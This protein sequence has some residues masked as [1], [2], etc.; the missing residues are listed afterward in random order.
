LSEFAYVASHDLK[1]PLSVVSNFAEILLRKYKGKLLDDKA[2]EFIGHITT[3][4]TQMHSL[5][6]GLLEYSKVGRVKKTFKRTDCN[7]CAR[8]AINNLQL[9]IMETG[10]QVQLSDLPVV[11]GD[12]IQL[13]QLF[14]NL[15]SNAIKFRRVTPLINITCTQRPGDWFISIEDNGIGIKREYFNKIFEVFN[16]LHNYTDYPGIG[17]GLAVCKKIVELHGGTISVDSDYGKGSKFS[18]TL[19]PFREDQ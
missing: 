14:Q 9:K 18:F 15:I 13:I 19:V 10:A 4:L 17:L 5:I 7:E 16:R 2:Q 8:Q 11:F 6:D 12:Q 3:G 1:E